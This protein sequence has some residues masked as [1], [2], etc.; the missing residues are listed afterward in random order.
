MPQLRRNPRPHRR[1]TQTLPPTHL[2]RARARQRILVPTHFVPVR[3]VVPAMHRARPEPVVPAVPAR[4]RDDRR[5]RMPAAVAHD[6]F[7]LSAGTVVVVLVYVALVAHGAGVLGGGQDVDGFACQ[8]AVEVPDVDFTVV[9]AGVDVAVVG[10]GGRGEVAAD[11]GFEDAVAAEGDEGAVVGVRA[12]GLCVVGC[13]AVVEVCG[14]VLYPLYQ[15]CST[16][17]AASTP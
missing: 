17:P 2:L 15:H 8:R 7:P 10:R 11:E 12:V 3:A 1:T 14:E 5:A 9:G 4:G 16:A 13:E 6:G